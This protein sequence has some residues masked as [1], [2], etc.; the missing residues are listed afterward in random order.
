MDVSEKTN[1]EIIKYEKKYFSE[2]MDLFYNSSQKIISNLKLYKS[3][4]K[5]GKRDMTKLKG[6]ATMRGSEIVE[7]YAEGYHLHRFVA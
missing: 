7:Q 2:I 4:L 5:Q 1:F 3:Q 6:L